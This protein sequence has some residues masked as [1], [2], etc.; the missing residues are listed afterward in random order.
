MI[1]ALLERHVLQTTLSEESCPDHVPSRPCHV[2]ETCHFKSVHHTVVSVSA[3]RN[4]ETKCAVWLQLV[5]SVLHNARV[6]P[7]QVSLLA[8]ERRVRE[9]DV[10]VSRCKRALYHC[11]YLIRRP[12]QELISDHVFPLLIG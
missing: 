6:I 10:W 4:F 1:N 11:D 3:V 12:F 7:G 2:S 9:E 8:Q 5:L